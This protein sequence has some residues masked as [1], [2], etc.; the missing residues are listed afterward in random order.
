MFVCMH[1][2]LSNT[3]VMYDR[4]VTSYIVLVDIAKKKKQAHLATIVF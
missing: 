1:S 3:T 2:K 4:T